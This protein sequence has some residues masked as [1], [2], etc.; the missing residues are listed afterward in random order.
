[1]K[2]S[3]NDAWAFLYP[4]LPYLFIGLFIGAFIYG[5]I[6]ADFIIKYVSGDDI[7]S[8]VITSFFWCFM[9]FGSATMLSITLV[10]VSS[11]MT[12]GSVISFIIVYDS[13]CLL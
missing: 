9:Y 11:G 6:P 1:M 10:R 13:Y 3:S 8:V 7:F 2:Q 5:F 4:M 12:W